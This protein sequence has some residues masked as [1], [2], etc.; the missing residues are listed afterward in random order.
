MVRSD[1]GVV[2]GKP[3]T[4]SALNSSVGLI[5]SCVCSLGASPMITVVE[6]L[7]ALDFSADH[8]LTRGDEGLWL[9]TSGGIYAFQPFVTD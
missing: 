4:R 3:L 8:R 6:D 9:Y 5:T 7:L 1:S 2:I